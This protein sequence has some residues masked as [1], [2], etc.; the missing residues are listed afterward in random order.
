MYG[1]DRDR[2]SDTESCRAVRA[3]LRPC[4]QTRTNTEGRGTKTQAWA[5][6]AYTASERECYDNH[7][8]REQLAGLQ[9]RVNEVADNDLH[10]REARNAIRDMLTL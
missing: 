1:F 8:G 4:S 5:I 2:Y 6:S 7:D 9:R 10:R 3:V